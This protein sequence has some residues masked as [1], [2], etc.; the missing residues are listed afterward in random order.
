MS[1]SV[2]RS[3]PDRYTKPTWQP[4]GPITAT[5]LSVG[6]QFSVTVCTGKIPSKFSFRKLKEFGSVSSFRERDLV[7]SH[8]G[9]RRALDHFFSLVPNSLGP[10]SSTTTLAG[11]NLSLAT[12]LARLIFPQAN[13]ETWFI[14]PVTNKSF[15]YS[16]WSHWVQ[17]PPECFCCELQGYASS[18]LTSTCRVMS[19]NGALKY[20]RQ[21]ISRCKYMTRDMSYGTWGMYVD[22][23]LVYVMAEDMGRNIRVRIEKKHNKDGW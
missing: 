4:V 6:K 18:C 20:I 11:T 7:Q 5:L 23:Y 1:F 22:K 8:S 19:Y 9:R 17:E 10:T 3:R 13:T 12:D 21:E 2:Q 15:T 16:L 14:S